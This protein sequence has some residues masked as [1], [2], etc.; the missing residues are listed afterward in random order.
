MKARSGLTT[1]VLLGGLALAL[2]STRGRADDPIGLDSF[3][4][5]AAIPEAAIEALTQG[6]HF[7]ASRILEEWLA[8]APDTTP[9]ALVLTARAAA[10]WY[11]W[12]RVVEL[13]D[14]R[15]WLD[16]VHRGEGWMLLGQAR[17]ARDEWERAAAAFERYATVAGDAAGRDV[18]LAWVRHAESL[19]QL[20]RT[21][22]A[23]AAYDRGA[24]LVPDIATWIHVA[25]AEAGAAIGDT[26]EV[27]AR[28]ARV[29]PE[30]SRDWSWAI[31]VDALRAAG[32][33]AGALAAAR[34][35]TTSASGASRRA[36]AWA[37]V[38]ALADS[39]GDVDTARGAYREAMRLAPGT[40][41]A[42]DAAR[43]LSDLPGLSAADRLAIG[44]VYLRHGNYDRAVEGIEA[45]LADG[46]P[47]PAE[48]E[49]LR[50][51]LAHALFN[52][53]RYGEAERQFQ[54][55]VDNASSRAVAA[56]A[57]FFAGRSQYRDGRI[58]QGM[59]TFER[60]A[61]RYPGQAATARALYITAD[62]AQD[63][64]DVA[65][66]RTEF[67][68]AI[69][70]GVGVEEVGF[71]SMRLGGLAAANGDWQEAVRVF[72]EYRRRWPNGRRYGQA[73]YWS[74]IANAQLGNDSIAR[75]R[76]GEVRRLEPISY[77]GGRAAELLGESL[78]DFPMRSSPP[79]D[80]AARAA[81][82][83]ALATYDLLRDL[84]WD[85]A[86]SWQ[87][88]RV[89]SRFARP[90]AQ[91]YALAE[92]LNRRGLAPMGI[93][94]GWELFRDDGWNPR[95]LR[96]IYPFPFRDMIVA[97][98]RDRGVDPF[99]AAGLIRQ[100]SM[101]QPEARSG[102]NAIGLMQVLP[103]T[104]EVLAR[105]LDVPRFRDAM[106]THPEINVIL[107]VAYLYDQLDEY[108]GRLPMVLGAYN[109]G[110]HRIDR[111]SEFPEF[112]DDEL[113]AERI[114][115]EETREYVKIVQQN[116]KLYAAL[117]AAD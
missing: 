35:A 25:A 27:R 85:D 10:G 90:A 40:L 104:G 74:G 42:I 43:Y 56:E 68:R 98:A 55:V 38:A 21:D 100:E 57:L 44:R 15:D 65:T 63:D 67:R 102:A 26:A 76:F 9:E 78:L 79:V 70:S 115:F 116:A 103:E 110:P 4:V 41:A 82:E 23:L 81:V 6:R 36:R 52:G 64:N 14:G 113:F 5:P 54:A 75:A 66:A 2:A 37:T 62:L 17:F 101:F 107:G 59:R 72:D 83:E 45:Y 3:L 11:D 60:V 46:N 18:A 111:W 69:D 106:L 117:W 47:G 96:I 50:L 16:D 32:D 94:L 24:A 77:Y 1:V 92:A 7:R 105:R 53:R 29:E 71:A 95:L 51:E 84:D 109:A 97:E 89:R 20:Q 93:A 112:A 8:T 99:L 30:I 87:L 108:D 22:D 73:T 48:R 31:R 88:A 39:A 12:S 19:R 49:R 33:P 61:E 86:A 28:L 91:G 58:T 13:L 34:A 114:P 80:E